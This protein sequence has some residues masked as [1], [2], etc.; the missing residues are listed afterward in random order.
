M[1]IFNSD[2]CFTLTLMGYLTKIIPV[3]TQN[4]TVDKW[5]FQITT[6][7]TY[8]QSPHIMP[9]KRCQ[10]HDYKIRCTFPTAK[11]LAKQTRRVIV[12]KSQSWQSHCCGNPI[13]SLSFHSSPIVNR[14]NKISS[15]ILSRR[16][17]Q[18]ALCIQVKF[19]SVYDLYI[20]QVIIIEI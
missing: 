16:S 20:P 17:K 2:E 6:H 15:A 19:L 9:G 8:Y 10:L 4:R 5:R 18:E 1:L 14:F 3:R 7:T 13:Q 11:P 12:Q